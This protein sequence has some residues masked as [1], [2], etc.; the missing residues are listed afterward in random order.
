MCKECKLYDPFEYY[1]SDKS[2]AKSYINRKDKID[3][4]FYTFNLLSAIT[5]CGMTAFN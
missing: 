3:V 2:N 1:H 5:Q 4:F